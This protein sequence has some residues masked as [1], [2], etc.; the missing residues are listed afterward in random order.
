MKKIE[1]GIALSRNGNAY[2]RFLIET[3]KRTVNDFNRFT[4][5][6]G[7]DSFEVDEKETKDIL[8]QAG[9][10]R[11]NSTF[12]LKSKSEY[13]SMHHGL[14]LDEVFQRMTEDICILMDCD[15]AFLQNDWDNKMLQ[16]LVG[17]VVIVGA[18]YDGKKYSEFPNVICAMFR[19]DIIKSLNVSFKP[20]GMVTITET[21][22]A[23]YKREVAEQIL[24]DTGSELPRKIIQAGLAGKHMHLHRAKSSSAVFMKQDTRGEE[25]QLFGEPVFTHIGR[26]FTR[27]FGKDSNAIIWEKNV[28]DWLNANSIR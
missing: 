17:D 24:L 13:G 4:F 10:Y 7:V 11:D 15:V 18:E 25:Y 1:I 14:S 3:L 28:R 21:N 20:E 19:R 5:I 2:L 12:I 26:S 16:T 8:K 23:W 9:L 27:C 22:N 6:I